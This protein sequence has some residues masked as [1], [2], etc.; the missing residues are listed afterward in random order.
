MSNQPVYERESEEP[1]LVRERNFGVTQS[2]ERVSEFILGAPQGVSLSI[3]TYGGIVRTLFVPDR[4]GRLSDVVLG[5]DSLSG[6]EARHPYFGATV[7]RFANRIARGRFNLDGQDY[8]LAINDEPNHLHGGMKGFDRVI[9]RAETESSPEVVK[10]VLSY[11][12]PDGEEG[13]PGE[14]SVKVSYA[15][16]RDN[17]IQIDYRAT[18]S[19]PTPINLTNHSYFNLGG[20]NSGTILQHR[21]QLF[22][23]SYIPVDGTLIPLGGV[24]SVRGTPFD[25]R[26]SHPIGE[27]LEGARGG[28]DHCFV[29]N[30][31]TNELQRAARVWEPSSGRFLEVFTTEPGVQLYTGN[32]LDGSLEGKGGT[33]YQKYAG[34]CLETQHFPDSVNRPNFPSTILRPGKIYRHSTMWRF[35]VQ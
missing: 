30:D 25:F 26:E 12:S 13:Y 22:A 11:V 2:G 1:L 16:W 17:T 20:H 6:Y 8:S 33:R 35:G 23:D 7:G 34:L 14:V 10:V 18:T 3:L 32:F 29:V 15:L 31:D 24:E 9:W 4:E 28:Y 27:F 19:R 5:F 21:L